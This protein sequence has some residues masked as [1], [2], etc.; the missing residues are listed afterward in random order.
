MAYKYTYE[1]IYQVKVFSKAINY[2]IAVH[3][4]KERRKGYKKTQCKNN[5]IL[6]HSICL[7]VQVANGMCKYICQGRGGL[8]HTRVEW[9]MLG[10]RV[11]W[12]TVR[13]GWGGSCSAGVGMGGSIM[14][15][16][17]VGHAG[18]VWVKVC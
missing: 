1:V 14:G 10:G 7:A 5:N 13:V 3:F 17:V 16:N 9:T 12:V 15:L 8:G 18:V 6:I 11:R 2:I 4:L